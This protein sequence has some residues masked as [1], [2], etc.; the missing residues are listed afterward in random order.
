ML[1]LP[2]AALGNLFKQLGGRST[3]H[4]RPNPD[5]DTVAHWPPTTAKV[6][7][8]EERLAF[9][10]LA[11]ALSLEHPKGYLL[12]HVPL[13]R[14]V[15]VSSRNSYREWL[16]RAGSLTV[17]FALCDAHGYIRAAVLL[18]VGEDNARATR[19]RERLVRVLHAAGVHVLVWHRQWL[20][21]ESALCSALF[22]QSSMAVLARSSGD[23]SRR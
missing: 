16:A 6:L 11:K 13:P 1:N 9:K 5:A 15:R 12:A 21:D 8:S 17:D 2:V 19:R 7:A 23:T 14:L 20:S 22:P 3:S 18:P 4:T 10:A